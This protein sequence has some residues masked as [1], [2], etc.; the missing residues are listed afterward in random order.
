MI[1][2]H[3]DL[4]ALKNLERSRTIL[5]CD[6]ERTTT[7]LALILHHTCNSYRTVKFLAESLY[8]CLAAVCSRHLD[9]KNILKILLDIITKLY[10]LRSCAKIL[11]YRIIT[12]YTYSSVF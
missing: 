6:D 11:V 10:S 9:A 1:V 12:R 3:I 2:R 4:Y 8:S 5:F 7:W